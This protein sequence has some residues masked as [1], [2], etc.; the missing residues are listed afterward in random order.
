MT[1]KYFGTDGI[2]GPVNSININGD[3]FFKF[4]LA[5]G[6]Y[7]KTQNNI[8]NTHK[9]NK[10]QKQNEVIRKLKAAAENNTDENEI[11]IA[12]YQK[13]SKNAV[14]IAYHKA[15]EMQSYK[16]PEIIYKLN[17]DGLLE[18]D[19]KLQKKLIH[20]YYAAT[21]YIDAQIGKINNKLKEKGLDKNKDRFSK[22]E[23]LKRFYDN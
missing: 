23:Y 8:T 7:F 11:K 21:S 12:P 22:I 4:G 19:E 20:G 2:R 10:I 16:T 9:Y 6:T 5:S 1:K 18:L 17:E 3:M 14:D 15:G 13:K